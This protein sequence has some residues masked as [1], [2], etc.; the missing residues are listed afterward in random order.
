[1]QQQP[2]GW[3]GGMIARPPRGPDHRAQFS[4]Q[5]TKRREAERS[6]TWRFTVWLWKTCGQIPGPW[7]NPCPDNRP[8]LTPRF[9]LAEHCPRDRHS[10]AAVDSDF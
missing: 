8:A 10:D 9:G 2:L 4:E 5:T 7:Q 6:D 3:V 1:M